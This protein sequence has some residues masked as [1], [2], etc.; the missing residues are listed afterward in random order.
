MM[1]SLFAGVSGLKVHQTRMDVIGNNIANVNTIGFKSSRTTFSDMLSQ[2]QSSAA[3]PTEGRGGVNPRQIGLGVDVES[4]DLIFTDSSPQQTGK[5]TDLALSGNG[6][7]VLKDGSNSYY[8]R[9]GAFSFDEQGYYVMPGSGLRVQ[10]WN[11]T[12]EG[13]LNTNG[14]ATDIVVPVGKTME[15]QSTTSIAYNGNL[16]KESQLIERITFTAATGVNRKDAFDAVCTGT[17][18]DTISSVNV[19]GT[20][21]ASATIYMKDGSQMTVTSGYYEVGKSVPITTLATVYDS[22]GG[23]HEV[24]I[25]IDKDP[26]SIDLEANET[27]QS[28]NTGS[29]YAYTE[30]NGN[31]QSATLTTDVYQYTDAQNNTIY[32]PKSSVYRGVKVTDTANNTE[33]I[34]PVTVNEDVVYQYVD[35]NGNTQHVPK[36]AVSR[37]YD[38]N[39]T[40]RKVSENTAT[41][42]KT[43]A[44]GD[45][46]TTSVYTGT[47]VVTNATANPPTTAVYQV[48]RDNDGTY[49]Y[50]DPANNN[51]R[52]TV[53]AS[54]VKF[55]TG[56]P[57]PSNTD[58]TTINNAV[59]MVVA[60][61]TE[62]A[63]KYT[64]GNGAT[65]YVT[66]DQTV[67]YTGTDTEVTQASP[68]SVAYKYTDD[69]GNTVYV[70]E[71]DMI[72]YTPV[73]T[74]TGAAAVTTNTEVTKAS[75]YTYTDSDGNTQ[76]VGADE[77]SARTVYDNRWRVYLA[78][79]VG[80][81]G[82]AAA[83]DFVNRIETTETD[84]SLTTAIMNADDS[85]NTTVSYL[86]FNNSGAF[87]TNGRSQDAEVTF[88]YANGNGSSDNTAI[89]SFTGL[90]QYSNSTT[91]FPITNGNSA[92]ILQS[93]SIDGSGIINGTYTNGL[94]RAEAQIAVAQF[95]NASG[96]TKAGTT[97]YQESNNSGVANIKTVTD[98]GLNVTSSALEMSNVDLATEFSD[99]IITQR[100]FQANSKI[101]TVSDEMLETL[102]NM[103]R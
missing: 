73:T 18:A 69:S 99:M 85:G 63:Y 88:S 20:N 66:K 49:Y 65:Q 30:A 55:Y 1:R 79:A 28:T 25:L 5:N 6:L 53:S 21:V 89:F 48:Q 24:T 36:S 68:S 3:S 4:I 58:P 101:T 52:T 15:A 31:V 9:N 41:V 92:G 54:A 81:K 78:P 37:G 40:Y 91:S 76:Y 26:N 84:G 93:L 13:I 57:T 14:S 38:D 64:D 11:A 59:E 96:L 62:V 17:D 75:A 34:Y 27:A 94:V 95:N 22:Q 71:S 45:G 56:T 90:T 33:T 83:D 86:Y 50:T 10:G 44:N 8:T 16:N 19:D 39:G 23:T 51:A 74:G 42:Y 35:N 70:S 97:I 43:K 103:K 102:V 29:I 77:V 80:E 100:G 61:A 2:I 82:P 47:E 7:F 12:S 72:R 60:D 67:L 46:Y 98:F 32:V 87:I